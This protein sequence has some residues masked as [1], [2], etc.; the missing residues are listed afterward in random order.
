[1]I[2]A[3]DTG[4]RFCAKPKYR[5]HPYLL[6]LKL[7]ADWAREGGNQIRRATSRLLLAVQALRGKDSVQEER[8]RIHYRISGHIQQS[9]R[10][11]LTIGATRVQGVIEDLPSPELVPQEPQDEIDVEVLA[12]EEREDEAELHGTPP[13]QEAQVPAATTTTNDEMYRAWEPYPGETQSELNLEK[14][15][16][17]I[18]KRKDRGGRS[19]V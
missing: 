10:R 14:D 11:V 16:I 13:P 12:A 18:V 4:N 17:V 3:D 8:L 5:K 19:S 1:M 6:T 9:T 15:A 2:C 7:L